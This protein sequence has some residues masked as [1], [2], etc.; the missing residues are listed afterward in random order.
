M[1]GQDVDRTA[2]SEDRERDLRYGDPRRAVSRT[3]SPAPRASPSAGSPS[4]RS[5]SPP[6]HLA[7]SVTRIPSAPATR[8]SVTIGISSSWPHSIRDTV[9]CDTPAATA[10]SCL[11]P[12]SPDPDGADRSADGQVIHARRMT[13]ATYSPLIRRSPRAYSASSRPDAAAR[14][15]SPFSHVGRASIAARHL[16]ARPVRLAPPHGPGPSASTLGVG[17][18][19]MDT[20]AT[21]G[22]RAG[23]RTRLPRSI[24]RPPPTPIQWVLAAV[25]Q[26]AVAR[27]PARWVDAH[28]GPP[29]ASPA[30][31]GCMQVV[32]AVR[33]CREY[34]CRGWMLPRAAS[35]FAAV[36]G[37]SRPARLGLARRDLAAEPQPGARATTRSRRAARRTRGSPST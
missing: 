13:A 23:P 22:H 36:A 25:R 21:R 31:A 18:T 20:P 6:R 1:P 7:S 37:P 35:R 29:G 12:A 28:L 14:S 30:P 16:P 24:P 32:V 33:P 8:R 19:G 5:S 11:T 34:P 15:S 4:S 17:A 3:A 9:D 2:L 27:A 10:R 26:A